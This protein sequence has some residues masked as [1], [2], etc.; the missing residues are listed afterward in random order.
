LFPGKAGG[1][2]GLVDHGELPVL[3]VWRDLPQYRADLFSV[4]TQRHQVQPLGSEAGI[5]DVLG[6]DRAYASPREGTSRC[7]GG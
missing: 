4:G 3:D 6:G 5:G 2:A 1:F 7:Y